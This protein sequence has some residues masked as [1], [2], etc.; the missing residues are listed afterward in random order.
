[1]RIGT[2]LHHVDMIPSERGISF[3]EAA[4]KVISFG[5]EN[6]CLGLDDI[7]DA[8][9]LIDEKGRI[10]SEGFSITDA[11]GNINF[12]RSDDPKRDVDKLIEKAVMMGVE[13]LQITTD[14]YTDIKNQSLRNNEIGKVIDTLSYAVPAASSSGIQIVIEDYDVSDGPFSHSS[15]L[16]KI[17]DSVDGLLF[18]FDSGNFVFADENEVKALEL[19]KDKVGNLHFKD[20]KRING[21]APYWKKF[22]SL[23]GMEY[24]CCPVGSGD[25]DF[26]SVSGI[27]REIGYDGMIILE[28]FDARD[29]LSYLESSAAFTKKLFGI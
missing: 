5:I 17:L 13:R 23:G 3:S 27:I 28:H 6:I 11:Y 18:T 24:D 2:F 8:R 12:I 4:K 15:D 16:R 7:P 22:T 14:P 19:L 10:S 26:A 25:I 20:R 1:M 29:Q 9:H 21:N